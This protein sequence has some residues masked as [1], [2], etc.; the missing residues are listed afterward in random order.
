MSEGA[1]WEGNRLILKN[2]W[3]SGGKTHFVKEVFSDISS[4][5]F[6]QTIYQGESFE[7]LKITYVFH[8]MKKSHSPAS[9]R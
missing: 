2:R 5:S 3:E 9:S 1:S 6:T 4:T 7:T 8:A